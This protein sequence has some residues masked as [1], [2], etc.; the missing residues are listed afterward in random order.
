M[1]RRL[2]R[3][4]AISLILAFAS[5][6]GGVQAQQAPSIA[7]QQL[8]TWVKA[9]KAAK[10]GPVSVPLAGQVD[11]NLQ[12]GFAFVPQ[13]EAGELLRSFGNTPSSNLLGVVIPTGDEDWIATVQF[14][15]SGYIKDDDAKNWDADELLEDFREGTEKDNK[16]RVARGFP[17]ME[18]K[19]W[20][21]K[22]FYDQATHRLIWSILGVDK[23]GKEEDA[24]VNY[25]TYVL[26]R[27]G[28]VSLI[29]LTT[30]AGIESGKAVAKQLLASISYVNGKA[31]AD[32]N[33]ATDHVAEYG[34]AALV[35][36]AAAKKLGLFGVIAAF[37]AKFAKV[38]V[39]GA[40]AVGGALINLF[41]R[42]ASDGDS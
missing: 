22:P 42:K 14:I 24:S 1:V 13:P 2:M 23:G 37:L 7:E 39:V 29:I 35:A 20:I 4:A 19:G 38:F 41:R 40:L 32:F 34:L 3:L 8:V 15:K 27:E 21:E 33:P 10:E 36:G 17:E 11:F 12:P 30:P 18:L 31:Y 28:Y 26:G 5:S 9:R 16:D 6:A 25:N